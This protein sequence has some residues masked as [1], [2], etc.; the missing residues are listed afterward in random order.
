MLTFWFWVFWAKVRIFL[1]IFLSLAWNTRSQTDSQKPNFC[2]FV[3]TNTVRLWTSFVFFFMH[4]S[5]LC[6]F[7][8]VLISIAY[9]SI[10]IWK[11]AD[12]LKL[13]ESFDKFIEQSKFSEKPNSMKYII[14][15]GKI[16]SIYSLFRSA[17]SVIT[18]NV[19][20]IEWKNGTNFEV[21]LIRTDE[22]RA[23]RSY[24]TTTIF[25]LCQSIVFFT[26]FS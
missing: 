24:Y 5:Y 14:L 11:M 10:I 26:V 13:I 16:C 15:F 3:V 20:Q 22:S 12:I 8:T 17:Y 25:S 7:S 18:G 1:T 4:S 23:A 19:H 21:F 9:Y 2:L 6:N